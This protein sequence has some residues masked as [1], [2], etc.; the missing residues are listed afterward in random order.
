MGVIGRYEIESLIGKGA[1][2]V[3]FLA[4][5][6]HLG[7]HVALK[8][9]E[10]PE[11][12]PE[13][14]AREFE[15]RLL[16]EALAAA[17]LSHPNIVTVHD[18]GVDPARGIPYIVME[19]VPG[20]SLKEILEGNRR[21]SFS[22]ALRIA[23]SLAGALDAAHRSGVVHRDIKPANILVRESDGAVKITDF[24]VARLQASDLTRTGTLIGSP[25]YMAPEQIRGGTADARSDL[26]SLAVVLYEALTAKR[27][28]GGADLA[29]VAYS[30]A[31]ETPVPPSR[32]VRT[33]PRG[34]DAFFERALAKDPADRFKDGAAFLAGLAGIAAD[35]D[36]APR[37]AA[38]A[39]RRSGD[40]KAAPA[41]DPGDLTVAGDTGTP[42]EPAGDAAAEAAAGPRRGARLPRAW[43]AVLGMLF[44]F[45]LV[46]VPYL[47]ATRSAHLKLEAKS[48]IEGG[49]LTL[50]VDG[51]NLYEHPLAAPAGDGGLARL[52]GRN[53]ESFEAWLRVPPGKHELTAE[54]ANQGESVLRDTIV[55]DLDPG[56]NRT[57]RLTAGRSFGRPLQIK[58]E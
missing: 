22:L 38:P 47:F 32:V 20:R 49:T 48:S 31:H 30:V 58:L 34:L 43:L 42:P 36:R 13:E 41:G 18:A 39:R 9:C 1:M 50:R 56:Q 5:D 11:G 33:L 29:S 8:T 15:A 25:A 27:P 45:T 21:L 37:A 57:L 12:L 35:A 44:L 17:A 10:I 19:Y 40:D 24:G 52:L 16:R 54:V 2:G 55:I 53:Q 3:V 26:F 46:G 7:R 28:F 4:R 6:P 23:S 51:R 14:A